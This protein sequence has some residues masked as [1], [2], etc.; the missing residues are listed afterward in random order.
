[1]NEETAIEPCFFCG[2]N[3]QWESFNSCLEHR[4]K[5]E[6]CG[7]TSGQET[8]GTSEPLER[9][10]FL[11]LLFK[12]CSPMIT[13]PEAGCENCSENTKFSLHCNHSHPFECTLFD[14]KQVE[15]FEG[16]ARC[17]MWNRRTR[18]Q[19]VD[20]FLE[21]VLKMRRFSK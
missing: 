19:V 15:R 14:S 7:Y 18:A 1:M 12:A 17:P 11:S 4:I 6:S 2:G 20:S 13:E 21:V 9:H 8:N 10:N 5:C 3:C 16:G